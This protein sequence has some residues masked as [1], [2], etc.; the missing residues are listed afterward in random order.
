V[1]H[2]A[3]R[4]SH[5]ALLGLGLA[6]VSDPLLVVAPVDAVN[7]AAVAHATKVED[8]PARI[9]NLH[10]SAGFEVDGHWLVGSGGTVT[11]RWR[12]DGLL[13]SMFSNAAWKRSGASVGTG[14]ERSVTQLTGNAVQVVEFTFTDFRNR[15]RSASQSIEKS[16]SK[17]AGIVVSLL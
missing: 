6:A 2:E 16:A 10:A 8:P 3:R 15:G 14:V 1:G 13:N 9:D 11:P 5:L 7:L 17:H 12:V 4:S